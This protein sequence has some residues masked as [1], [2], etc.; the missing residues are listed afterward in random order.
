MNLQAIAL[1]AWMVFVLTLFL[2]P[3]SVQRGTAI[4]Y[5]PLGLL[6]PALWFGDAF[7]LRIEFVYAPLLLG[8]AA[9]HSRH[10]VGSTSTGVVTVVLYGTHLLA[11]L[12]ST[13]LASFALGQYPGIDAGYE[14]DVILLFGHLRPLLLFIAILTLR[15]SVRVRQLFVGL[16]LVAG[17]LIMMFTLAQ[18]AGLPAVQ[19]IT[20]EFFTSPSRVPVF[21]LLALHGFVIRGTGVFETPVSN[22]VFILVMISISYLTILYGKASLS[23][24]LRLLAFVNLLLAVPAGLSTLTSTFLLGLPPTAVLLLIIT[25]VVRRA[26]KRFLKLA[27][28]LVVS[29]GM[30]LF[31]ITVLMASDVV[32]SEWLH[33]LEK[34]ATRVVLES[35]Y[36]SEGNL[37]PT[38]AAIGERPWFGWGLEG[39][40][41][42]FAGDSLYLGLLHRTGLL[43]T[44]P[45]LAM[46]LV[47][48]WSSVSR[49]RSV[50]FAG[51]LNAVLATWIVVLLIGGLAR[52]TLL[53]PR[54]QEL[55]WVLAAL[56]LQTDPP[57]TCRSDVG[58]LSAQPTENCQYGTGP[59]D[60]LLPTAYPS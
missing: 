22:A 14:N 18:T 45:F 11:L 13:L 44:L 32:R 17:A 16:L 2:L 56:A 39:A 24:R 4:L 12:I 47:L 15:P 28:A 5:A 50:T 6:F 1:T 48:L 19:S 20:R 21:S 40:E 10:S 36:G 7:A 57:R 46:M 53:T 38:M 54:F 49:Y 8:F 3:L 43:G 25:A 59:N 23:P 51:Y 30:A 60:R 9:L 34:V 26:P 41:G 52:A 27:G 58:P 33:Q 35:R 55:F 29:F 31:S 42:V 37:R